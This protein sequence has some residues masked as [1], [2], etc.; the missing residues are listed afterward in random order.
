MQEASKLLPIKSIEQAVEDAKALINVERSNVVNG[1]YTRWS[2]INNALMKYWRF[3]TVTVL[4]GMSG[5]GKSAIL[6]MIEDDFTNPLL[7]PTFQDKIILIA[8]KY[9]M[10]AA[11]EILRNL[12]GKIGKSYS[13]LLSS[14]SNVTSD[15]KV[16]YNNIKDDEF[17]KYEIELDKLKT[18]PIKYI[19]N[20]GNLEQ[21][22]NT[23]IDIREKNPRKQLIIT[24]DHTLLSKKLN[25]K[26]DL[27]LASNTSHLAIRLRKAFGA[28]VIFLGQLNGEIEKPLRR[29]TP[30]L[31]YPVKT[32]IHCG[33]QIFWACD[34]VFIYHRPEILHITKYGNKPPMGTKS[35]IHC[36]L[37]KS[38]KN[39]IGNIWFKEEFNKGNII[40]IEQKTMLFEQKEFSFGV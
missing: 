36:A 6:N 7:N 4:A 31:H 17:L 34:N 13:Y 14:E 40:Q 30:T 29:E 33:N 3:G 25:E 11:D 2:G 35:L 28:M 12:S 18:K 15:G 20:A 32:D 37:I 8:F 1:L 38:R 9:E 27:E 5:S 19:E 10:D 39:K 26:D 22:W 24:L 16:S 21:L 23:V